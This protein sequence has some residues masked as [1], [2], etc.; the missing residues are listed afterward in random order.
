M[1]NEQRQRIR[2]LIVA[3]EPAAVIEDDAVEGEAPVPIDAP[4]RERLT[5][6]ALTAF[7]T[8]DEQSAVQANVS[9]VR[10]AS[11]VIEDDLTK[12]RRRRFPRMIPQSIGVLVMAAAA[13][14]VVPR[15]R[16]PSAMVAYHPEL[17]S[18]REL[19][20]SAAGGPVR[21]DRDSI[22][23]LT[24]RPDKP[25]EGDMAARVYVRR[26][27][28]LERW[29][30]SLPANTHK[31]FEVAVPV[32]GSPLESKGDH[33]LVFV[34][35]R[36]GHLP[37]EEALNEAVRRGSGGTNEWQVLVRAVEVSGP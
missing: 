3:P 31:R 30:D 36:P 8:S 23:T 15:L 6:A 33:E 26:G 14:L 2:N 34:I 35:G 21:L 10:P 29:L 27:E 4:L 28:R 9:P 24:L 22:L 19:G 18:T 11:V 37:S 25:V 12:A 20:S 5:D 13:V 7:E 17:R 16:A 1:T 32:A